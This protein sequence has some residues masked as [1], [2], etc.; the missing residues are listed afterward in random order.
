VTVLYLAAHGF[1]EDALP[2]GG[3]AAVCSQLLREWSCT[4]PF[5]VQLVS[6]AIL[7][8]QAGTSAPS[9]SDLVRY[10]ERQ[11][12]AFCRRFEAAATAEVLRHDPAHT[13]VLV[14]DI[15]EGPDFG[16]LAA[17][18]YPIV[19]IYHVD[20]V[21]Y[22][23]AI[24]ARR[25]VAPAT[26]ARCYENLRRSPFGALI[27]AMASLV[28]DKQRDSLRYSRA[29]VVPSRSMRELLLVSYPDTPPEKIH[30]LPWGAC[31]PGY[32]DAAVA[33]EAAALRH[34]YGIPSD[35]LVLLTLSR[36]SPEKGQDL[37]LHALLA[38][39]RLADFPRQPLWLFI[40]GDAAYMQGRRFLRRLQSLV[41]RLRKTRVIFPG[42]VTGIRKQAFF[43]LAGLYVFPSRHESY[44]LTL[45][46]ALRAGLPAVCLDH[47]GAHEVMRPD[48]GL[49]VSEEQLRQAIGRLLLDPDLRARMGRAA[50][51]YAATLHFSDVAAA[52]AA[53]IRL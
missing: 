44:G 26:L 10:N 39:E 42:H 1:A 6:P 33:A 20:V 3:G 5:P 41:R 16:R 9:G 37:L 31:D 50:R 52:L 17:A 29:V 14:N 45:V 28:F 11:Y 24:Y 19:T 46:E 30:V 27:P 36:I 48:C 51:N 7:G 53:I 40:C 25:L 21:A 32:D 18:G 13:A 35:A 8:L 22:V 43:A 23:A 34:E 15:S 4:R 47:H 2:L 49:L 12:A 38:W